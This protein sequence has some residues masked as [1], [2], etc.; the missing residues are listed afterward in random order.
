MQGTL[1]MHPQYKHLINPQHKDGLSTHTIMQ[2]F[3]CNKRNICMQSLCSHHQSGWNQII[4][5]NQ[6]W[7]LLALAKGKVWIKCCVPTASILADECMQVCYDIVKADCYVVTTGEQILISIIICSRVKQ[8]IASDMWVSLLYACQ[9]CVCVFV[10][11]CVLCM[12]ELYVRQCMGCCAVYWMC[13]HVFAGC[14]C[15]LCIHVFSW[16]AGS[17]L[18]KTCGR[19]VWSKYLT[20]KL[21]TCVHMWYKATEHAGACSNCLA[22]VCRQD[23]HNMNLQES[24][25]QLSLVHGASSDRQTSEQLCTYTTC[26]C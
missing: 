10:C 11:V 8:S 19:L 6:K 13:A 1:F 17:P 23:I 15:S 26:F 3:T 12:Y 25:S 24:R 5:D 21:A 20:T 16:G 7:S 2:L 4:S 22:V 18:V 14:K 9:C